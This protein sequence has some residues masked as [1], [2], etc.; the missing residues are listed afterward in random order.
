MLRFP[1]FCFIS[2]SSACPTPLQHTEAH[3]T[4]L[5]FPSP[6]LFCL[7]LVFWNHS[8][9]LHLLRKLECLIF[10]GCCIAERPNWQSANYRLRVKI[11]E[12]FAIRAGITGAEFFFSFPKPTKQKKIFRT[13]SLPF[14]SY[15]PFPLNS[16]GRVRWGAPLGPPSKP[17]L[18]PQISDAVVALDL[19]TPFPALSPSLIAPLHLWIISLSPEACAQAAT[20]FCIGRHPKQLW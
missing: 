4:S 1:L 11:T 14:H 19:S 15:W 17:L 13:S 18:S 10:S 12:C 9:Y 8:W 16:R 2:S 6:S 3:S 7:L 5:R 20:C